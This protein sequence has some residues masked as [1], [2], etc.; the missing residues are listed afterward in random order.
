[1]KW[2]LFNGFVCHDHVMNALTN[3]GRPTVAE[4]DLDALAFNYHQIQRRVPKGVSILGVVKANAYGHGAIPVSRKF[5]ENRASPISA[6]LG[7]VWGRMKT[8]MK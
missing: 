6:K 3:T 7:C 5:G 1:M 8:S 2:W 4:I